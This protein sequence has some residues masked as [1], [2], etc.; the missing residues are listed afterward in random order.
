VDFDLNGS[1]ID[2]NYRIARLGDQ[3]AD[4]MLLRMLITWDSGDTGQWTVSK[5]MSPLAVD[6]IG[7]GKYIEEEFTIPNVPSGRAEKLILVLTDITG[8]NVL[9]AIE[10]DIL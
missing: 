7:S 8:Q 10:R 2:G 3:S 5:V 4:E 1:T 9:Y 6:Q